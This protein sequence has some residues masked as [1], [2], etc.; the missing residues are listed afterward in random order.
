MYFPYYIAYMTAG[1]IISLAVFFWALNQ[2]QFRD[3]NRA[4]F[5]PLEADGG[6]KP[7]KPSRFARIQTIALFAL[8]GIGL[9]ASGAVI[10]FAQLKA[11]G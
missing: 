7:V 1:F 8:V 4:R 11:A 2:G 6:G 5:I 3:Q 9:A 10:A